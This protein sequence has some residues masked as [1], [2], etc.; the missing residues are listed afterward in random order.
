MTLGT[1]QNRCPIWGTPATI[2]RADFG[3]GSIFDSV[4]AGGKFRIPLAA[5]V[6]ISQLVPQQKARLTTMLID[7]REL[8]DEVPVVTTMLVDDAKEER[9]LP[10]HERAERLLR[11]C[12]KESDRI[13]EELNLQSDPISSESLA[14]SE[15]TDWEEVLFL[16]DYL[17]KRDWISYGPPTI[18]EHTLKV[19]V[20]GYSHLANVAS[21]RDSAQCFVA[22]WFHEDM[23]GPYEQG[24]RPAVE[25]AGYSPM[26]IDRKPDLNKID[27]EIIAEIRRSRFLVADFT[28]GGDGARGSVYYETGFAYGLGLPVIYTC[29]K[30]LLEKIHFD[31]RQY[32]HT[33]WETPDEL[34]GGLEKR[35]LALIGEGP[36]RES[37]TT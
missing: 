21:N 28:H 15:S 10:V 14:W 33:A 9:A 5:E 19:T 17:G 32:L 7:L 29:R 18:D 3:G 25:A 27:D 26:R 6:L 11:Y 13:G 12:A 24:I 4:R 37:L 34:R 35:I 30:D 23:E 36:N 20:E 1:D 2:I 31:T 8:G 22:M 16:T